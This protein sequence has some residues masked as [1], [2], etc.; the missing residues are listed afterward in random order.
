MGQ[1][2]E[3]NNDEGGRE[4]EGETVGWGKKSRQKSCQTHELVRKSAQY[5]QQ[6]DYEFGRTTAINA[7]MFQT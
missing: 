5:S 1:R 2:D 7:S 3:E 4:T 6:P